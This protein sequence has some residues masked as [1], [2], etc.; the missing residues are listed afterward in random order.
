MHT[1]HFTTK[2]L[3]LFCTQSFFTNVLLIFDALFFLLLHAYDFIPRDSANPFYRPQ[4]S[5]GRVMFLH[6]CDSVHRGGGGYPSMHCRWYPSMP[7]SRSPGGAI[8]ACIAGGIPACLAAGLGGGAWCRPPR[9][10]YCCGR[11]TS[12][13]NAFLLNFIF[14]VLNV[15]CFVTEDPKGAPS[16]M[17]ES[18]LMKLC[19]SDSLRPSVICAILQYSLEPLKYHSKFGRPPVPAVRDFGFSVQGFR[20]IRHIHAYIRLPSSSLRY[21]T[22]L[23]AGREHTHLLRGVIVLLPIVGHWCHCIMPIYIS[24]AC[25]KSYTLICSLSFDDFC[26]PTVNIYWNIPNV[27]ANDEKTS[28]GKHIRNRGRKAN[29]ISTTS[30]AFPCENIWGFCLAEW[31]NFQPETL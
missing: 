1:C 20:V 3:H 31:F 7:C 14:Q 9:D 19:S 23:T 15:Q 16:I 11:Y 24:T 28:T 4:R 18:F 12:Y 29:I 5:W 21:T 10:G 6:V 30:H 13:W 8:P 25:L 17:Y 27:P 22:N 26:P 2:R